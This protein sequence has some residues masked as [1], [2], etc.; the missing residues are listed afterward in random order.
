[1]AKGFFGKL[2]FLLTALAC[3]VFFILS[4]V[5]KENV[6]FEWTWCVAALCG[7]AGLCFIGK[8]IR[9]PDVTSKRADMFVAIMFLVG[10]VI[11]LILAFIP[12]FDSWGKIA[13]VAGVVVVGLILSLFITG[14]K[15][16][17]E[18]DNKKVG[19]KNYYERK[20]EEEKKN[21]EN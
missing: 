4:I 19:Y 11:A 7:V 9:Q 15:K 8:A 5:M 10:C 17:D 3:V 13:I 2:I 16:W 1:M 14:G 6:Q 21:K 18:G 20:A 12:E